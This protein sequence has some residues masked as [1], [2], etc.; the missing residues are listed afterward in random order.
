MKEN[1]TWRSVVV[2]VSRHVAVAA[3]IGVALA[4]CANERAVLADLLCGVEP[5]ADKPSE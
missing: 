3:V 2:E 5:P 4:G 1:K